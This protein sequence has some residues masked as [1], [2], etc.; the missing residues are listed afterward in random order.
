VVLHRGRKSG[1]AFRTP[2]N[3]FRRPGGWELPLTYGEGDWVKNVVAAREVQLATR[4]RTHRVANPRN[5]AMPG[6]PALPRPVR[7]ILG[8]L[9]VDRSLLVDEVEGSAG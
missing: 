3:A 5:V 7:T 4:G 9:H 2:V 1:R 8:W 6:H